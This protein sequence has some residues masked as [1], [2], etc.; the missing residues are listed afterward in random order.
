[1]D[2]LN[3]CVTLVWNLLGSLTWTNINFLAAAGEAGIE[4]LE[5]A[6]GLPVAVA[7]AELL[8]AAMDEAVTVRSPDL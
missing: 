2:F 8:V 5:D 3:R 6:G 1:M 4:L 7:F